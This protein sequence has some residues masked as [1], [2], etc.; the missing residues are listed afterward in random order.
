MSQAE[1][2]SGYEAAARDF[3]DAARE[4]VRWIDR[5]TVGGSPLVNLQELHGLLGRVQVAVAALPAV[6]APVPSGGHTVA[7]GAPVNARCK[8]F[9]GAGDEKTSMETKLEEDLSDIYR[10]LKDALD[11]PARAS[12]RDAIWDWRFAYYTHWGRHLVHAQ[13]T[14]YS[15]LAAA[16]HFYG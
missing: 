3:E 15:Y 1:A 2:E 12:L 9:A 11:R 10:D 16:G 13:A 5:V 6:S 4:Y 8:I 7:H 14:V